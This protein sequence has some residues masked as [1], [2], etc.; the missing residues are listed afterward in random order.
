MPLHYDTNDCKDLTNLTKEIL[1][2]FF[3]SG[4]GLISTPFE[5]LCI[6]IYNTQ[7]NY[8][9]RKRDSLAVNNCVVMTKEH[10]GKIIK[11]G[12]FTS[13]DPETQRGQL[14]QFVGL[15]VWAN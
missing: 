15:K 9:D 6:W 4:Q 14:K 12:L 10:I 1:R 7:F 8:G 5:V 3:G 13:P 11:E 2:A